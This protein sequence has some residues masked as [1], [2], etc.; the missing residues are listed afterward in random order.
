MEFCEQDLAALLDSMKAAFTPGEV[1]CLMRQL[2]EG[3]RYLHRNFI[4]HRYHLCMNRL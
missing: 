2:L 4:I 3:V 1:K